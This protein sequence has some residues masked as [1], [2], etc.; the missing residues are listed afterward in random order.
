MCRRGK[1]AGATR[2][3]KNRQAH[4]GVWQHRSQSYPLA[5]GLDGKSAQYSA[6]WRFPGMQATG[7]SYG[8]LRTHTRLVQIE[9]SM[10][11]AG[12]AV[13]HRGQGSWPPPHRALC[14]GTMLVRQYGTR[15]SAGWTALLTRQLDGSNRESPSVYPCRGK[16]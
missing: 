13:I 16:I 1:D 8:V 4:D 14:P 10:R 3:F 5:G 12:V 2:T 9:G 7:A 6:A 11:G 15:T